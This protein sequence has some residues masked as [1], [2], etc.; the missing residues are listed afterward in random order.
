VTRERLDTD[1][2]GASAD[3]GRRRL[4]V[5]SDRWDATVVAAR[6]GPA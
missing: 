1:R 6:E 5:V 3:E 4:A 2:T